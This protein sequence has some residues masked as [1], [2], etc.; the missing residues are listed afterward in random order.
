MGD[1]RRGGYRF[2]VP[3][4]VAGPRICIGAAFALSEAQIILATL[5][6]RYAISTDS[7]RPV[8]PV[9]RLTILPSY[10]PLFGLEREE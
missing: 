10:T 9:G 6:Q 3:W 8:M 7:A 2:A 4:S 5:L 1:G